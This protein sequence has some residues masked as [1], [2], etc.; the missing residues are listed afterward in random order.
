[1]EA[2]MRLIPLAIVLLTAACAPPAQNEAVADDDVVNGGVAAPDPA[3]GTP[4]A[5]N[6]AI[7]AS[8]ARPAP[9]PKA[10]A[11]PYTAR[12]QEPGWALKIDKG[13]IDYQGNYGETLISVAS[14]PPQPTADGRRY[15]T[16]RLIVVITYKRCNDA[17]SGHGYEHQVKVTA[18][19][20]TFDGCGGKRRTDWDM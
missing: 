12:G 4:A 1:M 3:S 8:D 5:A 10:A 19:G 17:M 18:D 2:R 15:A 7:P 14:P 9:E 11:E 20:Q 6:A 13:R 16:D